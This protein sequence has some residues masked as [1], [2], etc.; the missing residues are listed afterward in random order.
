MIL[1]TKEFKDTCSIILNAIDNSELSTLTET[2]ELK[3]E[4]Q[5]LF[6]NVT[7]K[8]Y[9]LS[10][11]FQLEHE[12]QFHATINAALF[13]KLINAITT[14]DIELKL[15][16]TYMNIKANG[17]YKIPLIFDND[18]LMELPE[19]IIQNKTLDMNISGDILTSI[20][21]YNSKE[22]A[23]SSMAQPVQKLYYIDQQGCITFTS[24]ACV[25][26]F[27]LEKPIKVLFNSRL[28]KLFKLFK[29]SMVKFSLGYDASSET[30]IQTK[31]LFETDSIKLTVITPSDNSLLSKVPVEKIRAMAT[32]SY[33]YSIVLNKDAMLQAINRL[34]LFS[35]KKDLNSYGDFTYNKD[36]ITIKSVDDNI[37]T[38][39]IE[40]GSMV[41][42]DYSM[43]L[44]L[45]SLKNVLDTCIEP[46]INF[47]F[48][49]N[50]AITITRGNITNIIPE[51]IRRSS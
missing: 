31:L 41:N 20:L 47:N 3:T 28:V 35:N 21:Q 30:L 40:S 6:L 11:K 42:D 24:G 7:N 33:K 12:E 5:I 45:T 15:Y 49:D 32:K 4:G 29:L 16:D 8:E 36:N 43:L 22:I 10:V 14:E 13:L 2:L 17:I 1:K 18:K 44:N 50:T 51:N 37:E 38:I 25:N 34:L 19:I 26:K 27:N 46:Y 23:K 48:G 39:K 9:Y